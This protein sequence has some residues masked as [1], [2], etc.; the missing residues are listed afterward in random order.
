MLNILVIHGYVQSAAT[1]AENTLPL[2]EALAD[3]A[4][5]HYV[6]GPRL[7]ASPSRP[8]WILDSDLEHDIR[9]ADRWKDVVEWW[10]QELSKNQY[11]GII[12][13]SQGAAMTA[14]LLSMLKSPEKVPGFK[15][16]KEQPIQFAIL[17]SGLSPFLLKDYTGLQLLFIKVFGP[18]MSRM[19]VYTKFRIYPRYIASGILLTERFI[20][21]LMYNW[22]LAVDPAD[23]IVPA[24]KTEALQKLF[25]DSQLLSHSEG[26]RIPV[27]G[28]W[29]KNMRKFIQQN[30]REG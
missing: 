26:H 6:D 29:P 14:L 13:L 8:W 1:V 7:D 10:S 11:D 27:Q 18:S 2:R 3:I 19:A 16:T 15:V 12:G 5:L 30:M 28:N 9:A 22:L 25:T 17:C 24:W 23:T 21:W 20:S 4:H